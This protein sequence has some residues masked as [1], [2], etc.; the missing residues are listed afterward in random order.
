MSHLDLRDTS[1]TSP[2]DFYFGQ[3]NADWSDG[4]NTRVL[5]WRVES[6]ESDD[7][8]RGVEHEGVCDVYV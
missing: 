7:V 4:Q 2:L 1:I 3:V 6:P 8:E 5:P